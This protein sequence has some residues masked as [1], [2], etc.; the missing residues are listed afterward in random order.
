MCWKCQF[1]F[2]SSTAAYCCSVNIDHDPDRLTGSHIH[3]HRS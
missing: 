1:N 2:I 3:A